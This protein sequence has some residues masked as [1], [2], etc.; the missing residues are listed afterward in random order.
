M[1]RIMRKLRITEISAVDKPAQA[2]AVVT[3]LKRDDRD[4][5]EAALAETN[6]SFAKL[7]TSSLN[8]RPSRSTISCGF[9]RLRGSTTSRKEL[10]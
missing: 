6:A 9:A 8:P 10:P 7:P 2:G 1:R 4:P 3:I 5:L